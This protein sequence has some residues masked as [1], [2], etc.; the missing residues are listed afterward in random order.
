MGLGDKFENNIG[1][2]IGDEYIRVSELLS[3][4]KYYFPFL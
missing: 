4:L 3:L 1:W 2:K